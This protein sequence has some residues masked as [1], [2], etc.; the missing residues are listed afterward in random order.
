MLKEV[1]DVICHCCFKLPVE[2]EARVRAGRL[3]VFNKP[4]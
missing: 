4:E 2:Q 3:Y 1:S